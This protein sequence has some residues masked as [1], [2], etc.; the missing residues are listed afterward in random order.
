MRDP[1]LADEESI[2]CAVVEL[3]RLKAHRDLIWFHPAN[4]EE[5]RLTVAVRLKRMGV[6]AGVPDLA[7]VLPDGRAAFLEVKTRNGRFSPEQMAFRG[8]CKAVGAPFAI[9]R[10]VD[11]AERVLA[12]W[13]ALR[14]RVRQAV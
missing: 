13:G 1:R 3:L 5:R 6:V 11:E 2:H 7:F 8:R 9:A 10:S 12:S 4:G 14:V